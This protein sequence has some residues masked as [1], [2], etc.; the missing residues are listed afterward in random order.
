MES[1]GK[2]GIGMREEEYYGK[3]WME[4]LSGQNQM[5]KVMELNQKT[6]RFGLVLTTEE[7]QMLVERRKECLQEQQRVEF[8]D[9]ILS[10]LIDTFC[11]SPYVSQRNYADTLG[12]LQEIFYLYKNE[13]L[14]ELTDD[15]L[16][17]Y[18][19]NAF[20]GKCQGSLEYLEGTVLEHFAR[21]IR[22]GG[23]FPGNMYALE[24]EEDDDEYL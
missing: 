12:R 16:L 24:E 8:G 4:L 14:D 10:K 6:E 11:D 13:S 18:M 19:K 3:K 2:E 22:R 15:E 21:N 17:E 7:A 23:N 20:D 1:V 5:Q 9:T